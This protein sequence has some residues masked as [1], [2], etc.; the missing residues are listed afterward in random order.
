MMVL[1]NSDKDFIATGFTEKGW[2]D[3]RIIKDFFGRKRDTLL[4]NREIEK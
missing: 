1:C 2:H 3:A 4:V